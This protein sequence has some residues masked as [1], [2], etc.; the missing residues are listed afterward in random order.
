MKYS[1]DEFIHNQGYAVCKWWY[2]KD[3]IDYKCDKGEVYYNWNF[4]TNKWNSA[5]HLTRCPFILHACCIYNSTQLHLLVWNVLHNYGVTSFLF[6][7]SICS[8]FATNQKRTNFRIASDKHS[9]KNVVA[10]QESDTNSKVI[11]QTIY[12]E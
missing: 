12:N 11:P 3:H 10:L 1:I 8:P 4:H 9:T 5:R 7:P 6:R 2:D